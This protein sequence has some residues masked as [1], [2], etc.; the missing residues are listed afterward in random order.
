MPS[1]FLSS[2]KI[3]NSPVGSFKEGFNVKVS[4]EYAAK[5]YAFERSIVGTIVSPD[6]SSTAGKV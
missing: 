4:A 1:E 5:D 2:M 3:G 6:A